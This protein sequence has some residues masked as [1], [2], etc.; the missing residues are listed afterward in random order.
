MCFIRIESGHFFK[1]QRLRIGFIDKS[2]S[3]KR[4][5]GSPF[6]GHILPRLTESLAFC[7]V[8]CIFDAFAAHH[9]YI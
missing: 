6:R 7:V 2:W 3:L 8:S 1:E 4:A 5:S 9:V